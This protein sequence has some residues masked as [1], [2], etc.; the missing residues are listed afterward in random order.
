M[1]KVYLAKDRVDADL[2]KELLADAGIRASAQ[3]ELV[4]S[5]YPI[6]AFYPT[7][8]V[9]DE[10]YAAARAIA[11]EFERSQNSPPATA[12]WTCPKC[13]ERVEGRFKECWKCDAEVKESEETVA[14]ARRGVML[15]VAVVAVLLVVFLLARS[16][17]PPMPPRDAPPPI[18]RR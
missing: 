8:W 10:D 5:L 12:T 9:H 4:F 2:L 14:L 3:D 17:R 7:V 15:F 13:G 6:P 16:N 18:L 11:G 1:K